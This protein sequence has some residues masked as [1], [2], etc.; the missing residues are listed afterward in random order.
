MTRAEALR[1]WRAG[2]Q[3]GHQA[4]GHEQQAA[5]RRDQTTASRQ[6]KIDALLLETIDALAS[7]FTSHNGSRD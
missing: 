4:A 7:L 1:W 2:Y 6:A 3:A 5:A